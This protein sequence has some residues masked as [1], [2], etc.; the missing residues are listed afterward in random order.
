MILILLLLACLTAS[1]QRP[2]DAGLAP[3]PIE[4]N[5]VRGSRPTNSTPIKS[6][7]V[8]GR[9]GPVVIQKTD[10]PIQVALM[11]STNLYKIPL[12]WDYTDGPDIVDHFEVALTNRDGVGRVMTVDP[13]ARQNEIWYLSPTNAYIMNVTAAMQN[14]SRLTSTNFQW[15]PDIV[16]GAIVSIMGLVPGGMWIP[17]ASIAASPGFYRVLVVSGTPELQQSQTVEG[18]WVDLLIGPHARPGE[19]F[20]ADIVQTN[21]IAS[22]L[23]AETKQ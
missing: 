21:N 2:W 19:V 13:A 8:V 3:R 18:P 12:Y 17:E 9:G 7:I 16:S 20:K 15:R 23:S 14:G 10:E 5:A 11:P 4:A 6:Q 1:A 22:I